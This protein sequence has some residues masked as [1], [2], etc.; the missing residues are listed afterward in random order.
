MGGAASLSRKTKAIVH[1]D[2]FVP[3]EL[4]DGSKRLRKDEGLRKS[5]IEYVKSGAWL[6]RI[7]RYVPEQQMLR[8]KQDPCI[9]NELFRQR[10]NLPSTPETERSQSAANFD[11]SF[12]EKQKS[13][14]LEGY[15]AVTE[16]AFTNAQICCFL[17]AVLWP[18]YVTSAMY[19]LYVKYGA[20][21]ALHYEEDSISIASA[22]AEPGKVQTAQSSRAQT[23]FLG[24]A[25]LFDEVHM[26]A[27]L[28]TDWVDTLSLSISAHAL[29]VSVVHR[30]KNEY[31]VVYVNRSCEAMFAGRSGPFVGQSFHAVADKQTGQLKK[32][33]F[34]E[35]FKSSQCTKLFFPRYT[36]TSRCVLDGT[37]VQPAG[38]YALCAHFTTVPGAIDADQILVSFVFAILSRIFR[39]CSK[40][41]FLGDLDGGRCAGHPVKS[42]A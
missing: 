21:A 1:S 6:E 23:I 27:M 9:T 22:S 17:F 14:V 36:S 40:Q 8:A 39:Q 18:V 16:E 3:S 30:T 15:V 19:R 2:V 11:F 32:A 41:S 24:C 25:A 34:A 31:P 38:E 4:V 28:Q 20:N 5:F 33:R 26:L 42:G 13:A 35:A 10:S 7:A 37:A 29:A 12:R